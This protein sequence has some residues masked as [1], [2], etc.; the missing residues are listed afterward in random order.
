MKNDYTVNND[1]IEE[2]RT[3]YGKLIYSIAYRIGGDAVTN[4]WEDSVQELYISAMDAC[5]AFGRK[6]GKEF[7]EY[8]STR[9]FDKYIKS[10]LWNKKNNLGK[11]ITRK[12]NVNRH[13]SLNEE[14]L[15]NNEGLLKYPI[16]VSA[17]L[18][19]VTLDDECKT[20]VNAVMNDHKMVKPNGDINVSKLSRIMN[21]DKMKIKNVQHQM[22]IL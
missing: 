7:K 11:H 3:K 5:E 1:D 10:T 20:L 14:I 19:D 13:M 21:T 12:K 22:Y 18:F 15:G 6:S 16:D 4:S 17:L 2:I 8:F 9:E